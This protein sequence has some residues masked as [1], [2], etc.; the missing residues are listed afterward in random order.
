MGFY[1]RTGYT[2]GASHTPLSFCSSFFCLFFSRLSFFSAI[3]AAATAAATAAVAAAAPIRSSEELLPWGDRLP[4][5]TLPPAP[6][7]APA[8]VHDEDFCDITSVG[9]RQ[10]WC[11]CCSN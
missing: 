4:P 11:G 5:L 10:W 1:C 3:S 8:D 6:A 2:V 7:P 9:G